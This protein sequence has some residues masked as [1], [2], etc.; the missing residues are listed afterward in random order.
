MCLSARQYC[1]VKTTRKQIR[2]GF[3]YVHVFCFKFL[4]LHIYLP[5]KGQ[6]HEIFC[7]WFFHESVSP[8]PQSIPLGPLQIFSKI[9]GDIRK[10]RCTTGIIDTGGK[11]ATRYRRQ[12]CFWYQQ[13]RGQICH[14]YQ[15]HRQQILP[16]VSLVFVDISGK[17]ATG[18]NNTGSKF[19]TGIND[20]GSKFAT[21]VI[22][23]GNNIRLLRPSGELEGKNVS[24]GSIG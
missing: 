6:C 3:Y 4:S 15:R 16:P 2:K 5:L 11:F 22:A 13:H 9:P 19:A 21:G 14:G 20:T 1:S 18:V 10:S 7:F 17:F 8:Q 24:I 12:N 23:N